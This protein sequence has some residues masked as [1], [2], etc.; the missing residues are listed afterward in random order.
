MQ[1]KKKKKVEVCVFFIDIQL[2]FHELLNFL[3]KIKGRKREREIYCIIPTKYF[4]D[5]YFFPQSTGVDS[6]KM[7]IT[8]LAITEALSFSLQFQKDSVHFSSLK[9][10]IV[11]I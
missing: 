2:V 9:K 8:M 11:D 4:I 10:I 6:K 1:K 3:Q 7:S 5:C